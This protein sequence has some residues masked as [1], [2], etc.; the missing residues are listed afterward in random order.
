[1]KKKEKNTENAICTGDELIC[2]MYRGG[3]IPLSGPM[4]W[5]GEKGYASY[6]D[7][8]CFVSLSLRIVREY[9]FCNGLESSVSQSFFHNK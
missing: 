5:F 1:M 4:Q 8:M 7:S 3:E 2:I 9:K 6:V